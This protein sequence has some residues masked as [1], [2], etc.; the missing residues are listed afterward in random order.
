MLFSKTLTFVS[1]D[2]PPYAYSEDDKIKGFNVEILTEIFDRM[3]IKI[4]YSI[5]PWA[6]A[7]LMVKEGQADAIFPFFKNKKREEFTDYP[8]SF[9]SE[10]IAMFVLK[11]SSIT[12][13][14]ELSKLSAF[15]F[16]RVIGY[17]S[18]EKLDKA[19]EDKII[20][21]ET[22]RSSKLNIRNLLRNRFDILVDNKYLILHA[23]KKI[24]KQNEIKQLEPILATTKAYLGFSKRKN[25][26]KIIVQF[27]IIL[28]EIKKDGTYDRIIGSY[29]K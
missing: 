2:F 3:D 13:D 25:H 10:P 1:T 12:Y 24:N 4:N 5:L 28:K 7:V 26:K 21:I 17:S 14:G 23:L 6:R 15:K 9:T 8:N 20:K 11:D 27:N 22:V 16:G 18:G 29:F 19:I